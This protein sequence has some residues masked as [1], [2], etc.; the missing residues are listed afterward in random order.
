[1][2]KLWWT[3]VLAATMAAATVAV[4]APQGAPAS[5]STA[6]AQNAGSGSSRSPAPMRR[7]TLSDV[8]GPSEAKG[9]PP[10]VVKTAD[11]KSSITIDTSAAP[12]LKVWAQMKLAPVLA[13][14]YP[15]IQALLASDGF[16]AP[17]RV[18]ITFKPEPGVAETQGSEVSGNSE[19][20]RAHLGDEAVGAMVH[21]LVHVAQQYG[22]REPESFPG[23]L[24]EGI[25]DYIRFF[26]FEPDYH[27]AD[28][29]W[30]KKQNFAK[31]RFDGAYR[32]TANFLDWVTRKYDPQIVAKLNASARRGV[33]SED[34]WK[35]KS[36]KTSVELGNEWKEEK[37]QLMNSLGTADAN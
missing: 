19:W 12:E 1:M 15:R 22:D 4:S 29:V 9:A 16:V 3:A 27:G 20:F 32:Q 33:Y 24:T 23:W 26:K 11:K 34:I 28:D 36:G 31:V 35:A 13:L 18:A 2:R 14:W 10:L 17:T 5:P 21:E 7:V 6:G 30:L 8:A 37:A 25:A